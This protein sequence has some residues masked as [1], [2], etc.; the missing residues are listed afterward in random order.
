MKTKDTISI[1]VMFVVIVVLGFANYWYYTHYIAPLTTETEKTSQFDQSISEVANNI[2]VDNQA[3]LRDARTLVA[4]AE[5]PYEEGRAKLTLGLVLLRTDVQDAIDIFKEISTEETYHPFTRSQAGWYA[6]SMYLDTK[7]A[8]LGQDHIFTGDTWGAF[9]PENNDLDQE[10]LN[11]ASIRAIEYSIELYPN[12]EA[13][14]R[15]ALLTAHKLSSNQ[16]DAQQTARAVDAVHTQIE[17]A[18]SLLDRIETTD[19]PLYA[20]TSYVVTTSTLLNIA[21]TLDIL[22]YTDTSIEYTEVRAAYEQALK[23]ATEQHLLTD[24]EYRTRYHFADFLLRENPTDSESDIVSILEPFADMPTDSYLA[25]SLLNQLTENEETGSQ[26]TPNSPQNIVR[27]ADI[28]PEFKNA[29]LRIGV[30]ETQL[31]ESQ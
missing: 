25:F 28:S 30:S 16:D 21:R 5:S 27:L 23:T 2:G 1:A 22:R 3:A 4:N 7:N 13:V 19:A 15:L 17:Y 9:L 11:T 10:D 8:V 24:H 14:S 20:G 29:L 12:P 31:T 6:V 26:I 18:E